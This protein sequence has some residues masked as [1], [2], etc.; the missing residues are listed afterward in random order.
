MASRKVTLLLAAAAIALVTVLA[1]RN[2]VKPEA[3]MTEV[4]QPVIPVTE[5]AVASRDLP[6]GTILKESDMK[7]TPWAANADIS[8]MVVKGKQNLSGFVGA[9][10]RDGFRAGDPI[11]LPRVAQPQDQGFM[12]AVLTPGMRAISISLSPTSQVA[13]FI[14]PG[15]R[16]D[17]ILTHAFSRRDVSSLVERRVSETILQN[18]RILALDQR[19]DNQQKDPKVAQLATLEV[20][21]K[22]AERMALAVDMASGPA[23]SRASLT[24]ALR[25]LALDPAQ[26]EGKASEEEK[27]T[28]TWDSDVSRS[29][30][31]MNGDDA[32]IHRVQ[33]IRGKTTT[34]NTFERQR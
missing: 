20:T 1:V 18:V 29:F 5:I 2:V 4:S 27:L 30:P 14:F 22:D 32:L 28:P 6:T 21:R 17:V 19:S 10:V 16:V 9:V 34:E 25:S 33:V 24:L 11:M 7:W 3:P 15:D 13:G 31:T 26:A 8:S 23:G 12:A